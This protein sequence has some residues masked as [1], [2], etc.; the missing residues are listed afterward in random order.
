MADSNWKGLEELR[1]RFP[2]LDRLYEKRVF[3]LGK[4]EKTELVYIFEA[5]DGYFGQNLSRQD[6]LELS[7]F[8]KVLSEYTKETN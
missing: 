2:L 7:K 4:D 8:F 1:E 3:G 5:C 6:C